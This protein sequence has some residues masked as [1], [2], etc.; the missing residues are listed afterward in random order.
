M[1]IEPNT[2]IRILKNIPLNN[3]YLNTLYW[4]NKNNQTNYFIS[5]TK[6]NLTK[7]SFQ[8]R[9]NG[10]CRVEVDIGGLYDC[11]Y[12]MFQNPS[13]SNKWFYAFITNVEYLNNNNSLIRFEIDD[14]QTWYFDWS[15]GNCFIE[16]QHTKSD[17]IGSNLV[18]ENLELGEYVLRPPKST[19]FTNDYK[20]CVAATFKVNWDSAGVAIL[21]LEDSAGG[22]YNGVYSGLYLNYVDSG[23]KVNTILNFASAP[24]VNKLDGIVSIFMLPTD[25]ALQPNEDAKYITLS[26][27]KNTDNLDGYTPRNKKLFTYPYCYIYATDLNG[28]INEYRYEDFST[29]PAQFVVRGDTSCNPTAMMYP[30][31]YRGV[32]NNY[33]E[34]MTLSGF[35]QCSYN[36]DFFKAWLSQNAGNIATG[37]VTGVG[38]LA[39]GVSSGQAEMALNGA[40]RI[41]NIIVDT[42]KATQKSREYHG[43]NSSNNLLWANKLVNF[44]LY[45]TTIKY[46][47]AKIIDDY[48][49][50][51]GYAIHEVDKPSTHNRKRWTY[52]KTVDCQLVN[53]SLPA[54]AC[55]HIKTIIDNGITFWV[56][57]DDVG[58][59]Y[60]DNEVL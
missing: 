44:Y 39:L 24:T 7:Q 55:K 2:N 9:E 14:M 47:F 33:T 22:T 23:E 11:N 43:G 50:C 1:Y 60:L 16:R 20:I 31:N 6:Y 8:R 59:Y 4:S 32:V 45:P 40:G 12:I 56:N 49:T 29:S 10:V 25:F 36:T 15:F 53:T 13:F 26:I 42:G 18:P 52:L 35:P 54:D 38:G 34:Q 51:Y 46:E 17:N 41:A 21:S 3:D 28:N 19:N 5:K 58:K 57:A 37:I 48:F 30:L 27:D